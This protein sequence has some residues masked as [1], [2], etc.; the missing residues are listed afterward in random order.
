MF[1]QRAVRESDKYLKKQISSWGWRNTAQPLTVQLASS[2]PWGQIRLWT[3]YPKVSERGKGENKE[4][5]QIM[6][7]SKQSCM[8]KS[9]IAMVGLHRNRSF[10]L[11][12]SW[13]DVGV[14][15]EDHPLCPPPSAG[16]QSY[17]QRWTQRTLGHAPLPWE[18]LK[19]V[20]INLHGDFSQAR[21]WN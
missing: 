5:S 20:P 21:H 13:G 14:Q 17:T 12:S 18:V 7:T 6:P 8:D 2:Q 3:L 1:C 16:R 11:Q 19:E 15:V 10:S 9:P 4:N